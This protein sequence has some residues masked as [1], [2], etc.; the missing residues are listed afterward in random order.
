MVSGP[1]IVTRGFVHVRENEELMD[2]A[3]EV[4]CRS[5]EDCVSGGR[6]CDWGTIKGAIRDDLRDFLYQ[7]TKRSPMILPIIMEV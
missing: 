3:R 5:V 1:D 6:N 2:Q 4:V 7:K